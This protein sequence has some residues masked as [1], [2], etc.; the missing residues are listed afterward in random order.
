MRAFTV[1]LPSLHRVAIGFDRQ[2][3]S[4]MRYAN[5]VTSEQKYPPH[6]IVKYN[7]VDYAIELAVAGFD[8]TELEV[9]IVRGVLTVSGHHTEIEANEDDQVGEYLYKGI[10]MR[11]FVRSIPLAENFVVQDAVV[12]NGIL[13]VNVKHIIPDEQKP[14]RVAITAV[15]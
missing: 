9:E 2:L 13:T 6:N 5:S 1:D 4:L 11:N 15:K 7:D 10:G 8:E 12:K 14:R 3:D